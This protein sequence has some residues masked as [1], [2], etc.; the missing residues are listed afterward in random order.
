MA[1]PS[2]IR[3]V[4]LCL[5]D[6]T[7]FVP[8]QDIASR[9]DEDV[10]IDDRWDLVRQ[11]WL[12]RDIVGKQWSIVNE[13]RSHF[14]LLVVG[15]VTNRV[16]LLTASPTLFSLRSRR[17]TAG[18]HTRFGVVVGVYQTRSR[19]LNMEADSDGYM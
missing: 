7:I 8:K 10:N 19:R 6:D 3:K 14:L 11:F 16:R 12:A 18:M 4:K 1:Q 9:Y 2:P 17:G 15:T 5:S 13:M